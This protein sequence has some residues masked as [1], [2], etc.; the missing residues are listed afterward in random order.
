MPT[1]DY[2]FTKLNSIKALLVHV[3]LMLH[4]DIQERKYFDSKSH[5]VGEKNIPIVY[6]NACE[7]FQNIDWEIAPVDKI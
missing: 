4:Y 2:K 3:T 7:K 1:R 6:S 5:L